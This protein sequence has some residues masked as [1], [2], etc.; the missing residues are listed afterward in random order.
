MKTDL[1][2]ELVVKP[3]SPA[4]ISVLVGNHRRFLHFLER[5]TGN[6]AT[7]EE[8]LQSAFVKVVERKEGFTSDEGAVTWF[9]RLLRNALV[10]HYR[11]EHVRSRA[12][13]N[14]FMDESTEQ[15]LKSEICGCMEGL[16][17]TLKD[18]YATMLTEVDLKERAVTDVARELGITANNAIVRLHRSRQALKRQLERSC[19]TCAEHGCLDCHCKR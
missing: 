2:S 4:V 5:K 10:D 14:G 18:E 6:T 17:T 12:I 15:E 9:Y 13:D 3:E 19:G 8:I 16:I 7:A 1:D 11:R